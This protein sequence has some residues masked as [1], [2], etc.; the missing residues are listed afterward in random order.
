MLTNNT[1]EY[2]EKYL[3]LRVKD[4]KFNNSQFNWFSKNSRRSIALDWEI[5]PINFK[6]SLN[7]IKSLSKP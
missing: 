2:V 1:I 5:L 4:K 6:T 7:K 3:T